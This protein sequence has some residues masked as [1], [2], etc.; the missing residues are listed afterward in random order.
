MG[1][2]DPLML[3][4]RAALHSCPPGDRDVLGCKVTVAN[5]VEVLEERAR[6]GGFPGDTPTLNELNTR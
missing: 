4:F 5:S 6:C 2:K 1:V 3:I